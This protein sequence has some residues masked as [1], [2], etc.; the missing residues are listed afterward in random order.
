[1]YRVLQISG[2]FLY[3]F[4]QKYTVLCDFCKRIFLTDSGFSAIMSM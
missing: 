3:Y 1:M 2:C 4:E